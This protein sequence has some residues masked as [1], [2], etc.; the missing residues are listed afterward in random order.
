MTQL[1]PLAMKSYDLAAYTV[2][3]PCSICDGGN[4][5]DAERCRVCQAP[6]ALTYQVEGKRKT[7]AKMV[8]VLGPSGCGKTVYL[9]TL[10]DMLSR[11]EGPLQMLARGA[12]SVEVQQQTISELARRRFPPRTKPVPESWNWMHCQVAGGGW[13]RTREFILPDMS[14]EAVED[15]VQGPGSPIIRAFLKKCAAALVLVD[16]QRL[17]LGDEEPDF[18]A[19]K[20]V[21]HLHELGTSRQASWVK[22]PVAVVFTKAD[23]SSS[24]F[25]DPAAF[26][27]M[28]AP[29]LW[30]QCQERLQRHRFFAASVVGASVEIDTPGQPLPIALR[31][32]PR[33]I[34]EPMEWVI[35]SLG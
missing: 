6:L 4:S 15:E 32:E 14:G 5:F 29:G 24:C 13:R 31:I 34:S 35:D 25:D 21:S 10:A 7:A 27:E 22:R 23:A 20:A 30:R 33:G 19:M 3:V 9:G 12:F 28:H 8:A 2:E 26:A 16:A 18:F 17:E 1:R 11:Q